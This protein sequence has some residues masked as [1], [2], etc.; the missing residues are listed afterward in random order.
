[1]GT[2]S[3]MVNDMVLRRFCPIGASR[4]PRTASAQLRAPLVSPHTCAVALST[5]ARARA[6][7]HLWLR[8]VRECP[9]PSA[10]AGTGTGAMGAAP[11]RGGNTTLL[12][13]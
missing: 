13:L 10:A 6:L 5:C 2:G 9:P 7:A 12:R 3:A 8:E 11:A 1:M 4:N